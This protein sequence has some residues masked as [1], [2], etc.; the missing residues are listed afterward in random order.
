VRAAWADGA[1]RVFVQAPCG[2]GKTEIA[3]AMLMAVRDKG[4]RGIFA[5]DRLSL[6][7]QT[8]ERFDKYGLDHGIIQ[9]AH[10]RFKPWSPIQLC[11]VQTL[12]RRNWPETDLL[13]SDEAHVL[14]TVIKQ[15]LTT[16]PVARGIAAGLAAAT[17]LISGGSGR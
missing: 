14:H 5:C 1:K 10:W 4:N 9:G 6:V 2:F 11:S 17:L 16:W 12:G 3:T 15:K 7:N 13:V 8:S